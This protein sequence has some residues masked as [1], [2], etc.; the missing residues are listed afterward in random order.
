[1]LSDLSTT[2][3]E[4][5]S[6]HCENCVSALRFLCKNTLKRRDPAFD[7]LPFPKQPR[8]LPNVLSQDEITRLI[9]GTRNRMQQ[10]AHDHS[11]SPGQGMRDRDVTLTPKLLDKL[12]AYWRWKKP[13]VYL[14][15]SRLRSGGFE[16]PISDKRCGTSA[17][18][19]PSM[20]ALRRD[21]VRIHCAMA[22]PRIY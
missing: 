6:K 19:R 14:F 12:R 2:R 11:H 22:L 21:L 9:D 15:P 10:P 13:Q 8:A 17:R 1:M 20:P 5:G 4:D 3:E 7:D 16:Q 18:R